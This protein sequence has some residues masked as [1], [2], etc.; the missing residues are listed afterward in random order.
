M[1]DQLCHQCFGR[2]DKN[3]LLYMCGACKFARYCSTSC[4]N[5][6]TPIHSLECRAISRFIIELLFTVVICWLRVVCRWLLLFTSIEINIRFNEI[7]KEGET[8]PLRLLIKI[9]YNKYKEEKATDDANSVSSRPSMKNKLKNKL[10]SLPNATRSL[11]FDDVMDLVDNADKFPNEFKTSIVM[12]LLQLEKV[13]DSEAWLPPNVGA[14]ILL[15]IQ[16]SFMPFVRSIIRSF[17]HLHWTP[18]S[19]DSLV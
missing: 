8:A 15:R 6:A 2:A 16:V 10:K 5:A 4:M 13:V 18:T 7:P 3:N 11:V 1:V 17:I 19:C 12:S 9:M 14:A